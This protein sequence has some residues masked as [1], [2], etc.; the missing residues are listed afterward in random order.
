VANL[1]KEV[2]GR[3]AE[4]DLDDPATEA[5]ILVGGLLGFSSTELI[6]RAG[7]TVD[8]ER[9]QR[10]RT[11]I[12]RRLAHEPVYR[13]IG[14]RE[15]Y[16]LPLR[17][18][19]ETLEPR[20]DTEILVDTVLP[21]LR[22]LAKREGKAHL[23]DMGTGTGAVC[24][25][26]LKECPE[27]TGVGSDIS[28]DALGTAQANAER[29]GLAERFQT[30]Q[31]SWFEPIHDRFHVIVSNPPYIASSIIP[32]LAPEVKVFDPPAALDGGRD[33]LDAYRAIAGDAAR[34]L[35]RNGLV[36]LEIG[37]DQRVAV[38]TIFEEA[39]FFLIEAACDYGGND[40][41]LL[42]GSNS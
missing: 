42:F 29:N 1:L 3:F 18:S 23:L 15:F 4:A 27:A 13:I 37:Y 5:R 33:G 20:P 35:H 34:F 12:E 6:S 40:R 28:T 7:E 39:G 19:A 32:T 16:G 25:A 38:T 8:P 14:E 36:G 22:D 24:I 30:V 10:V 21:H 31:G 41:V 26:L 11:A 17:L 9:L 2:R